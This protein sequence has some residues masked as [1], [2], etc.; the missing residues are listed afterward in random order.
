VSFRRLS[1]TDME[2]VQ[3]IAL[4]MGQGVVDQLVSR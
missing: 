4:S 2:Y 3:K 1:T